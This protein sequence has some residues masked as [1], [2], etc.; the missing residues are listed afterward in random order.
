MS[1]SNPFDDDSGFDL[2]RQRSSY[3]DKDANAEASQTASD[4]YQE[5]PDADDREP[6][7]ELPLG[8]YVD[9]CLRNY[10]ICA[11]PAIIRD[12]EPARN[13]DR[14]SESA[15]TL[16]SSG[17]IFDGAD[18]SSEFDTDSDLPQLPVAPRPNPDDDSSDPDGDNPG[19][20]NSERASEIDVAVEESGVDYITKVE[21]VMG[22][23]DL[24]DWSPFG[25]WTEQAAFVL[26]A[27]EKM[28]LSR[29]QF[30]SICEILQHPYFRTEDWPVNYDKARKAREHLPTSKVRSVGVGDGSFILS[31]CWKPF[32]GSFLIP[33]GSAHRIL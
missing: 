27:D 30:N 19:S 32:R 13:S 17:F 21:N 9:P 8:M 24:P 6:S 12:F 28:D 10:Y 3:R 16:N 11:N 31:T 20:D 7:I 4:G 2:G 5:L 29:E 23:D 22:N 18:S 33:F 1:T 25:S 26:L 14:D 15:F